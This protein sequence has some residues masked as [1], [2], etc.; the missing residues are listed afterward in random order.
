MRRATLFE[1]LKRR[2]GTLAPFLRFDIAA[3]AVAP[4]VDARCNNRFR[5]PFAPKLVFKL[6]WKQSTK[7]KKINVIASFSSQ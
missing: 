6:R 5:E 4:D 3:T 1:R 7:E 2:L